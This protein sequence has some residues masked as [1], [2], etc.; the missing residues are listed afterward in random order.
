MET[1]INL[2]VIISAAVIVLAFV[3]AFFSGQVY[4]GINAIEAEHL[5]AKACLLFRTDC[6]ADLYSVAV[7]GYSLAD[8]CI[9]KGIS[10]I[11]AIIRQTGSTEINLAPTPE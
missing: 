2:V 1:S 8:I 3:A 6:S 7:D 11:I 9:A 10:K 4:T 5:H